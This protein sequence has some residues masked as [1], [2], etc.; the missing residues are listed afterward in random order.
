MRVFHT[1]G[2]LRPAIEEQDSEANRRTH[3]ACRAQVA[4]AG[5]EQADELGLAG[6][7][8]AHRRKPLDPIRPSTIR[9]ESNSGEPIRKDRSATDAIAWS[10]RAPCAEE[11]ASELSFMFCDGVQTRRAARLDHREGAATERARK[12]EAYPQ[13]DDRTG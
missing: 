8:S 12:I 4:L 6:C 1:A 9:I 13:H 11:E 7:L 5:L 2:R 10:R 3:G